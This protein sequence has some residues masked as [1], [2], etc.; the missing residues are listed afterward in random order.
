MGKN[1]DSWNKLMDEIDNYR[2]NHNST[3]QNNNEFLEKELMTEFKDAIEGYVGIDLDECD[4]MEKRIEDC[5][6]KLKE[7][8]NDTMYTDQVWQHQRDIQ[9]YN[10]VV[11]KK[12]EEKEDKELL[13]ALE[14]LEEI[15][16]TT[17]E[18]HKSIVE[19]NKLENDSFEEI[20]SSISRLLE[21]KDKKYGQSALKPINIFTGKTKVGSRIDDKL[22]R[23]K[24][25]DDLN[26][27]DIVD[28]LGYLVLVCKENN[29]TN[30]DEFMD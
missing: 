14:D 16:K 28:I 17:K 10:E 24:N 12:Q 18:F 8:R 7:E 13:K 2:W 19:M 6:I 27:N 21:Y 9:K 5:L 11:K 26:K 1:K 23:I 15:S 3:L 30:F 22:S 29:W 4:S 25:S 20:T